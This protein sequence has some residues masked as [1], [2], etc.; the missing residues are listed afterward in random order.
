MHL[1]QLAINH[2]RLLR[3][4]TAMA[5]IGI[6]ANGG[7]NRQAL[8]DEDQRG[9]QL[10]LEWCHQLGGEDRRD[11]MGNL[12]VRWSGSDNTLPPI[13]MSS[14][15]D[16]QP[17]GGHF[18][19]VY[20][21]LAALEVIATLRD[22]TITTLHPL[23]IAVWTNEEGARFAPAM[24]G[25]GVFSGA[26]EQDDIYQSRD[27]SGVNVYN[28]LV[29][30]QQLG[31]T[32]CQP[33]PIFAALELH[34]EQGPILE[35]KDLQIGVVTGVQGM[36]W[37]DVTISGETTHAGPTPMAMRR[38]PM[39]LSATLLNELYALVERYGEHA[40]LT[41]GDITALPGSRNTVPSQVIFS[42][43]LR[44]PEQHQL[45]A[46]TADLHAICG[47]LTGSV[48]I[49]TLPIW[50][51]PAVNFHPRCID[52]IRKA[53]QQL[54]YRAMSMVSGAGHDSVYLSRIA[55]VGMIF[56]PCRNGVSHN[57]AEYAS[58]EQ[59]A[60]GANVLLHSLLNLTDTST[61]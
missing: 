22:A 61:D 19:G 52:A 34:I 2:S 15:L 33:F 3:Y 27:K 11:T 1:S 20:G 41:I 56:I 48:S 46:M 24:M 57:E 13:L 5:D 9:R 40:R 55:P 6:T 45:D 50:H 21:V 47:Q 38:D 58:P 43:D 28:A 44:H 31:N 32:P 37:F 49:Y 17:T 26:L 30:S 25:S 23:E 12:F 7:C 60:A 8:T 10:F 54:N 39:Q 14:H 42:V 59:L 18:D 16:T 51:S 36:N 53:S 35:A 4:L 29:S